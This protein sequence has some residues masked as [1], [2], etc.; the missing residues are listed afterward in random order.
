MTGPAAGEDGPLVLALETAT[1]APSV[2]VLQG[3]R[4]LAAIGAEPGA[5]AA[6]FVLPAVDAALR[7]A[8][9]GLG[10][11]ALMAVAIGPGSFTGLRVGL[12]TVKGLAFAG[13]PPVA[14]VPTLEALCLA[15]GSA[16][17]AVAAILDARRGE[18]YAAA[19]GPGP[20]GP[21]ALVPEDLYPVA[22]LADR[23]PAGCRLCGEGAGLLPP[24]VSGSPP[25][26]LE[27]DRLPARAVGRL[28]LR[29]LARGGLR[30]GAALVP[31]Y[32]RRAEAEARR[33]GEPR[34][35]P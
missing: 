7:S 24:G 17:F 13:H 34:E 20:E 5:S 14:A 32:L 6:A 22:A 25:V 11:L 21:V 30:P 23:L 19:Y 33:T 31:H 35:R 3:E 29:A 4:A 27:A 9:V 15:A 28:G 8:G 16:A 2:A 26:A 18:V 10:E 12:A 1:S